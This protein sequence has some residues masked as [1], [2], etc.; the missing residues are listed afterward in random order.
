MQEGAGRSLAVLWVPVAEVWVGWSLAGCSGAFQSG[1]VW[2][3]DLWALSSAVCELWE[4][5]SFS[6]GTSGAVS[7]LR[8]PAHHWDCLPGH[9]CVTPGSLLPQAKEEP[10]A[11]ERVRACLRDHRG[12]GGGA[13]AHV[14]LRVLLGQQLGRGRR[15]A[16]PPSPALRCAEHPSLP[17]TEPA[18]P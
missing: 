7:G 12:G 8:P 4:H 16:R 18:A 11:A 6:V 2:F 13:P 9:S 5:S 14:Q 15:A 1:S 3:A 10:G 17:R